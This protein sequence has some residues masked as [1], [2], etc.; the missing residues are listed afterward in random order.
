MTYIE[1]ADNY[2]DWAH[3]LADAL[4]ALLDDTSEGIALRT[5]RLFEMWEAEQG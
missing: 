2:E 5:L 3:L 1:P 4:R